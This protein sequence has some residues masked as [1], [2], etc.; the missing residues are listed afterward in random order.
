MSN[1]HLHRIEN[2]VDHIAEKIEVINVTLAA[3]HES[4]VHHIRRTELLEEDLKS[5]RRADEK[6]MAFIHSH[7]T[8][9]RTVGKIILLSL[10]IPAVLAA[11]L[12]IIQ[13]IK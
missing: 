6:Q 10:S 4:L 11:I 7:I 9:V 3:Q 12:S 2:K 13:H 5:H 1:E 8:S